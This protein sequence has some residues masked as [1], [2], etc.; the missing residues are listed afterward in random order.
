MKHTP[1]HSD[2][3]LWHRKNN[4]GNCYEE[5]GIGETSDSGSCGVG[6]PAGAHSQKYFRIKDETDS[7]GETLRE[8]TE[9]AIL[10]VPI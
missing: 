9:E 4:P 2:N 1:Y 5:E 6:C 10:Q 7:N 8:E 3:W